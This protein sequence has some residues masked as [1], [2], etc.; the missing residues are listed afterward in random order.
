[1]F[2]HVEEEPYVDIVGV[3]GSIPAAP[4]ICFNDLV[5]FRDG[6]IVSSN[7]IAINRGDFVG[8]S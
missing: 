3:A 7:H 5:V 8:I 2:T 4:T 6:R 1:M